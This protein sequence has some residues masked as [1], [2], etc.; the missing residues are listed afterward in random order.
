MKLNIIFIVFI[1][2]TS[3]L[4]VSQ[5]LNGIVYELDEERK[6]VPL[7]GVNVYWLGTQNGTTTD[8]D[9][10]FQIEMDNTSSN[11]LVASFVGYLNDTMSIS[12]GNVTIEI[13]LKNNKTLDEFVVSERQNSSF[14]SQINPLYVQNITG[15]ELTKAACCNLSESFETNVSVDVSYSDAVSGAKKIELLGLHGKYSQMM[16]ENIPNLR[17][18]ATTYGLGYIP[19]SWMESIQISKG[20]SSVVNGY[21]STTG[22]INIEYKKPDADEKLYLNAYANHIGKF[23]GN[24]NGRIK[25][26]EKW[27]TMLYAH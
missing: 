18:L 11:N 23:E 24:F 14:V 3:L 26:S 17:G 15:E 7:P 1:M 21:E 9:G 8:V 25:L 4:S 19:G 2:H 6:E 12:N 22:Q 13:V 20:A 10:K 5:V 16:T 27:S